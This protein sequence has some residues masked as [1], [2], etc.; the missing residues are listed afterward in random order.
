MTTRIYLLIKVF[1][2]EA[3]ADA[4]IQ[5]GELF[6]RTLGCFKKLD[7]NNGRGDRF[8]AVTGWHQ[9]DQIKLAIT[10]KDKD[11]VEKTVPIER[12]AGPVTIQNNGYDKLNLYCMYAVQ[13]PEFEGSY[14]TEEERVAIV[15]KINSMLK[16][17]STLSA[18]FLALGEF[19]VVVFQVEEFVDRMKKAAKDRKYACWHRLVEYYDPD[20]FH[21]SFNELEAVFKKRNLYKHQSEYRFVFGSHEPEGST[22]IYLGP[23]DGVAIKVP[24]SEINDKLQLKLVE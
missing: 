3:H 16:D 13:I 19:A 6:C 23:L 8:E 7:E 2:T 10:F 22:V 24:T 21:G 1:D 15:Q 20:K 18:D 11:G 5:K 4:F 17:R 14:E 12:I 9:P